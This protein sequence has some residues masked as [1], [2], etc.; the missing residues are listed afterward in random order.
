MDIKAYNKLVNKNKSEYCI[1]RDFFTEVSY[2][3]NISSFVFAIPNGGFR[4]KREA[5]FLKLSGVLSGVP[6][7]FVAIPSKG[8]HGLFLECKS[9]SGKLSANQKK[10]IDNLFSKNYF[11][12]VFRSTEEGISILKDYLGVINLDD[13]K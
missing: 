8:F 9:E 2:Y 3:K 4:N 5:Y 11:C 7:I 1:Q 12:S 10:C 13:Y 6:D